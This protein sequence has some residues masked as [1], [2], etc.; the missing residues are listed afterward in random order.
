[1][2]YREHKFT[3]MSLSGEL[4][5][6][7]EDPHFILNFHTT[8]QTCTFLFLEPQLQSE[9][10]NHVHIYHVMTTTGHPLMSPPHA[11]SGQ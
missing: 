4:D 5:E 6:Q 9:E 1:M 2:K 8:V 11:S 7:A 3:E 10:V